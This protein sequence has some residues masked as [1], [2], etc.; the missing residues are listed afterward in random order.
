MSITGY[1]DGSL[2]HFEREAEDGSKK[3]IAYDLKDLSFYSFTKLGRLRK[4]Q[5]GQNFFRNISLNQVIEG[6]KDPAYAELIKIV[7]DNSSYS[8]RAR[9]NFASMFERLS[10]YVHLE[11]YILLGIQFSGKAFR[12][13]ASQFSK[14]VIQFMRESQIDFY[15]S[16]EGG[17]LKNPDLVTNLCTYVRRRYFMDLE[18]YR[19]LVNMICDST[20]WE[21]FQLLVSPQVS[22]KLEITQD[23]YGRRKVKETGYGCEYKTLFDYLIRIDR[24]EAC[25][26]DDAVGQ[27][28]D[29]LK[30]MREMMRNKLIAKMRERNPDVVAADIG[31]IG[32]NK[33]EKY[34]KYLRV[35][36]D[37][38]AKN[39]KD[40]AD[41]TD[42]NEFKRCVER[43]YEYS[44]GGYH[45]VVAKSSNDVKAEGATLHHCVA[46]YISRI[47]D[48]TTQIVFMRKVKD[49]SLVTVEIRAGSIIQARGYNNRSVTDEETKWLKT[50][51]R[52]KNLSYKDVKRNE[53]MP[54]PPIVAMQGYDAHN[55]LLRELSELVRA[56]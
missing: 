4:V 47:L 52:A 53:K 9:A 31:F 50:F 21:A 25:D 7:K 28:R 20:Q 12:N 30:M 38:V 10:Q 39:Y 48:G 43:G 41:D 18:V 33:V 16:F 34:P 19:M 22:G 3:R 14:E 37:I 17:Y 27:L 11:S 5:A 46:S 55:A 45:M 56:A 6:F 51:A 29:Y 35:R 40:W 13:P 54:T 26:F 32:F 23:W 36:H 44:Y 8:Y 2:L 15:S 49:E 42:E 1:K 24:T